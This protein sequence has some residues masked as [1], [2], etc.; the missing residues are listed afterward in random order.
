MFLFKYDFLPEVVQK[1]IWVRFLLL[2]NEISG[3]IENT[4]IESIIIINVII[5]SKLFIPKSLLYPV[6]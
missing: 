6:S 5:S 4:Q 1:I 2:S 3:E